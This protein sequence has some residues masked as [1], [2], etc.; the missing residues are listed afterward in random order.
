V[1]HKAQ[2]EL[3]EIQEDKVQQVLQVLV[4]VLE[5]LVTQAQLVHKVLQEAQVH[6]VP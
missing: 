1:E 5:Q 2:Q 3:P 4:V 6:Q